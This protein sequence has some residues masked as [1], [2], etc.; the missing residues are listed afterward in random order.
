MDRMQ[1]M[2][3][4]VESVKRRGLGAA[5]QALGIS[6]TLVS[7][8]IQALETELGVRLLNRTTRS[9][10]LTDAGEKYFH[11]CDELL[12]RVNAM[13]QEIAADANDARGELSVLAPKW[14]QVQATRLLV[15]FAKAHPEI[16]PRLTLG[17][18]AQTAYG[19]L[20]QGCEIAL[21]TR[22]IPDSRILARR[23]IDIPFCL[24]GSPDYLA[25]AGVPS[26]PEHLSDHRCLTQ[27]NFHTWQ[28]EQA[29]Q[30]ERVQPVPAFATNTFVALREAAL[31]G[32]G[33]ALLPMPLVREDLTAGRLVATLPA[34]EPAGQ[35]LFAAIA[36]GRGIPRKVRLL[37]DFVGDWFTHHAL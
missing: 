24:S 10:S 30:V 28:F 31:E 4:F 29:G 6:R 5:S 7:R 23:L 16:R 26:R 34:W 15:A 17:G 20:E 21:H 1:A 36:P 32:L 35:V 37:L 27:Y 13:D 19:F 9:L 3:S 12:S 14:M 22:Q 25:A 18:M 2:E 33:L 11:F 8:N